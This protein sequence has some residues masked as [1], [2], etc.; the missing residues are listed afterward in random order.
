MRFNTDRVRTNVQQAT[1]E[2]LLDRLTVYAEEMEPEALEIVEAELRRRGVSTRQI[3]EH[4]EQRRT[5]EEGGHTL[6]CSFCQR[7]AVR[8][9]WGWHRLWGW[10]PLFPR[11]YCYCEEHSRGH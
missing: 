4:A 6:Q 11:P 1:T 5:L 7:P 10:V 8:R 2:D 3:R 9:G